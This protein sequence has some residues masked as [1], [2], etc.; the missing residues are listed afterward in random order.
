MR[1]FQ[2]QARDAGADPQ[3][4]AGP[5]A[6]APTPGQS[7]QVEAD[8]GA[9]AGVKGQ[10]GNNSTAGTHKTTWQLKAGKGA[11]I[12]K[13]AAQPLSATH[14]PPLPEPFKASAVKPDD[15]GLA[16]LGTFEHKKDVGGKATARVAWQAPTFQFTFKK[17]ANQNN[18]QLVAK[19]AKQLGAFTTE[20]EA[21]KKLDAL[22]AHATVKLVPGAMK[23]VEATPFDYA[24]ID[25]PKTVTLTLRADAKPDLHTNDELWTTGT[26]RIVAD[27]LAIQAD[28]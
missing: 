12:D 1:A 15:K 4:D 8:S 18:Q 5:V 13:F 6:D 2:P 19:W 14:A 24:P 17:V 27:K 23:H 10:G 26:V 20:R 21:Q 11:T 16:K 25:R 28:R 7:T 9:Q 22:G 3:Q